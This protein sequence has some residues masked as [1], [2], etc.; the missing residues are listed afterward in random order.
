MRFV[1]FLFGIA[2]GVAGTLAYAMFLAPQSQPAVALPLPTNPPVT[3]TLG[4]SFLTELVRHASHTDL[5]TELKEDAIVVHAN[6]EVLG[7][8]TDGTA[9]LRPVLRDGQLQIDVVGTNVGA[10]PVPQLQDTVAKQINARVHSLLEGM[11][12]TITGVHV[13]RE[14][15]MTITCDVDV[16]QLR[17]IS[18]R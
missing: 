14:H 2:I 17:P 4:Q 3:L 9:E 15:G 13:D 16:T 5:R 11:P 18:S 7:Q 1:L 8:A 12:V 6:M 10:I